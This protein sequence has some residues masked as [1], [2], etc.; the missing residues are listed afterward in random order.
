[1]ETKPMMETRDPHRAMRPFL[2]ALG[3][4]LSHTDGRWN[5]KDSS[6]RPIL[7]VRQRRRVYQVLRARYLAARRRGL[8]Q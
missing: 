5:L 1:L 6:G 2:D 7:C 8:V 4:S 3:Y